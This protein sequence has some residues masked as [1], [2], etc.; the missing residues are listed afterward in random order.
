MT[1]LW[2]IVNILGQ[3]KNGKGIVVHS[4]GEIFCSGV[5]VNTGRHISNPSDGFKMSTLMHRTL[6]QLHQLPLVTVTLVQ[7]KALCGGAELSAA[8]DFRK[9]YLQ[10]LLNKCMILLVNKE[11]FIRRFLFL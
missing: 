10:S 1:E 6:T 5:D 9:N 3:W 4:V 11:K 8:T 7:G 2:N